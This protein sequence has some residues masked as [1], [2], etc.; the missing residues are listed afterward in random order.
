MLFPTSTP[1]SVAP[2][3]EPRHQL[4]VH[5]DVSAAGSSAPWPMAPSKGSKNAIKSSRGGKRDFF[6]KR[7]NCKNKDDKDV[8]HL[9]RN[10][11]I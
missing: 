10:T 7:L 6:E 9:L 3:Y 1:R 5:A 11:T 2:R 8:C 4:T